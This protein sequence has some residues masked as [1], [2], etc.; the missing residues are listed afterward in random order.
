MSLSAL[1]DGEQKRKK[2]PVSH[3]CHRIQIC[4]IIKRFTAST[5]N[6]WKWSIFSKSLWKISTQFRI[7]WFNSNF[8][9]CSLPCL[10]LFFNSIHRHFIYLEIWLFP[11]FRSR[12]RWAESANMPVTR[13]LTHNKHCSQTFRLGVRVKSSWTESITIKPLSISLALRLQFFF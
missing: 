8:F 3:R 12:V 11:I 7:I 4:V 10:F 1:F 5:V 9:F 6:T 2:V 13:A